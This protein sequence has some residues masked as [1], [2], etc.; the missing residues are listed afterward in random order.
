MSVVKVGLVVVAS[1]DEG[2]GERAE[3]LFTEAKDNLEKLELKIE[4]GEKIIWD[5][6][7]AI[8][9]AEQLAQ[10]DL[11]L[12]VI[13]HATWVLDVIQYILVN[14]IRIPVI[15]WAIPFLETFSIACVQHF[16]SILMERNIFYKYVYGLPDSHEVLSSINDI[17]HTAK[18]FRDL[19]QAKIAL[20]GP[21]QTWRAAGS[22]DMTSEEWDL[23]DCFGVRIIHIGMDELIK[24]AEERSSGEVDSVLQNIKQINRLGKVEV[25]EKRLI[26]ACKIYLALKD[27]FERYDL[28]AVTAECY[29]NYSGLTNLPASWLVDEGITVE[30]EG[31][32]GHTILMLAMHW[33]G[34]RS[35][36]ALA[37]AGRLDLDDNCLWIAHEGSS[38]HSLAES[39]ELVHIF[40]G[41]EVGTVVGFPFKPAQPITVASLRGQKDTYKM[42]IS[43]CKTDFVDEKDWAVAGKKFIAKINFNCSIKEAF[44]KMLAEGV[45][46]H[47]L[48]KEGDI[49]S[50]LSDLCDL[51]KIRKVCL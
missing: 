28:N 24:K 10:K 6:A 21:R 13:I 42:F 32:L 31:D 5:S 48:L 22:Q 11:D 9:V 12:L 41:G 26:Y 18:V 30:T 46:H 14:T 29:P 49:T 43:K 7:D 40:E 3:E 2:G 8:K 38:A 33:L 37:E 19:G 51:L 39:P 20:I 50:Q 35:A 34:K 25:D 36:V 15:L 17:A 47:M 27:L 16:G 1:H 45:D 23:T 44:E 4:T